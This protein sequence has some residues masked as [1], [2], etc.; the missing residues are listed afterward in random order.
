MAKIKY[1]ICGRR[2]SSFFAQPKLI[3]FTK[4]QIPKSLI[5]YHSHTNSFCPDGIWA[6]WV[7]KLKWPNAALLKG[8]HGKPFNADQ[9]KSYSHIICVDFSLSF[10]LIEELRVVSPATKIT[11]I[12]HH[13]TT[14]N[15]LAQFSL[16]VLAS[17]DSLNINL[18]MAES[19]A[20]LTWKTLFGEDSAMPFV[21]NYVAD[22]DL[23]LHKL[24]SSRE[25]Y[26]AMSILNL[27]DSNFELFDMLASLDQADLLKTL[28]PIGEQQN[29][30]IA[31]KA[32]SI[33]QSRI[34]YTEIGSHSKF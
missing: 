7:A 20:T 19:G 17:D 2:W 30:F 26:A 1:C 6:A 32:A 34:T 8:I 10:D 5:I 22:H 21:L 4:M 12:D 27:T 3:I 29:N 15:D 11:I 33:V 13:K 28:L 23:W 24:E 16:A 18:D 25:I 9:L 31:S 14:L